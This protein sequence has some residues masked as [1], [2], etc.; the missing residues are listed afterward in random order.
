MKRILLCMLML[1]CV[2]NLPG[3]ASSKYANQLYKMEE[4]LFGIDY[5]D[6]SDE[7]RLTRLEKSVY[8]I[9]SKQKN[10]GERVARLTSDLSAD[11]LDEKI[12]PTEDS[13]A[14][15]EEL[16]EDSTVRY[17]ALDR[18]ETK[19][20]SRPNDK[21]GLNARIVKIEKH[22]FN[23]TYDKDDYHTRV[24]RIKN[25]VFKDDYKLASEGSYSD[26]YFYNGSG[27]TFNSEDLSGLNRNLYNGSGRTTFS[28]RLASLE[29]QM[30]GNSY[31]TDDEFDR[32]N[33]LDSVYRAKKSINKYDSNRFQQGMS[34]A[35]QIGAMLLMV[36]CMV[37]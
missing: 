37:L 32:L 10:L 33:R 23:Q 35:M 20:F 29:N 9:P 2:I 13:F 7:T 36:L 11:V 19:L 31:D 18:V 15:E 12:P 8:G 14:D 4:E 25:N 3:I 27:N 34:T 26:S 17:P 28:D 30:L 24:E 22:L 6:Q 5:S 1:I 21:S 16:A